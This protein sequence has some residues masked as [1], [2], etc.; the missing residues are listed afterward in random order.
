VKI[1]ARKHAGNVHE[2]RWS[3]LPAG[4][5]LISFRTAFTPHPP[6]RETL[7]VSDV[8]NSVLLTTPSLRPSSLPGTVVWRTEP[9]KIPQ[10]WY[11]QPDLTKRQVSSPNYAYLNYEADF[12]ATAFLCSPLRFRFAFRI[13]PSCL[14]NIF[15]GLILMHQR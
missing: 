12:C 7:H 15:E 2:D 4:A 11:K 5:S 8:G 14:Q 10:D 3:M 13:P 1:S 6:A 9:G